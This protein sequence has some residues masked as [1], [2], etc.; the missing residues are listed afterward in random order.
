MDI[1]ND[2]RFAEDANYWQT[3]V[4][5][6]KSQAEI[7]ELLEAFGVSNMMSA[8]GTAN[9]RLAW[10]IRFEWR[11]RA[12]RFTFTTLDPRDPD[13]VT[14]FGGV[15][16][17]HAD[18]VRYQMGRIAVHFVKAILTAAE[19]QPGALFGFVELPG[20]GSY[21]GGLPVVAS[22][23]GV[24]GMTDLLPRLEVCP[25]QFMLTAEGTPGR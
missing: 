23:L 9:G 25:E 3:T 11:G 10:L 16:R 20:A 17:R 4:H 15:P 12:Y 24:D 5:P 18:Q 8:Q 14:R 7:I 22:D 1:H 13:K 2:T 19:V 6:A 21:P